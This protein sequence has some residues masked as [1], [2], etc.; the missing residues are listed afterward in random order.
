MIR[1]RDSVWIMK[2]QVDNERDSDD[3][4]MILA[5][6]QEDVCVCVCLLHTR[7]WSLENL[8][9]AFALGTIGLIRGEETS[10]FDIRNRYNS[11]ERNIR[12]RKST[13]DNLE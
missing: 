9:K 4:E 2:K 5:V 1:E 3:K 12:P 11:T 13:D 10:S 8:F 7:E 6:V